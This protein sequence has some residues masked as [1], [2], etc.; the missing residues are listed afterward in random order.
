[1]NTPSIIW[2]AEQKKICTKIGDKAERVS[3]LFLFPWNDFKVKICKFEL[4]LTQ[5]AEKHDACCQK[6]SPSNWMSQAACQRCQN[7]SNLKLNS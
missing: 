4:G 1:M 7:H 6:T 2:K 3:D 5:C